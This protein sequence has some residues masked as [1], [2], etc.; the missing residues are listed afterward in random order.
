MQKQMDSETVARD[1]LE[2]LG[3]YVEVKRDADGNII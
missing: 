3:P 1:F 2:R